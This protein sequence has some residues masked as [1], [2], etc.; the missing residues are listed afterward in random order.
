MTSVVVDP[1]EKQHGEDYENQNQ[2][3]G[4]FV[5]MYP[6]RKLVEEKN[7]KVIIRPAVR[8]L[9]PESMFGGFY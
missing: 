6:I 2:Q 4:I 3:P 5:E 9:D 8:R 1:K 7:E